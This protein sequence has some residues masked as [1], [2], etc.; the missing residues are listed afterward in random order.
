METVELTWK[1]TLEVCSEVLFRCLL[2]GIVVGLYVRTMAPFAM[3]ENPNAYFT[4]NQIL[5]LPPKLGWLVGC[6]A[7][8]ISVLPV[9]RSVLKRDFSDFRV[10]L[11]P[12][13]RRTE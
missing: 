9:T 1:R 5:D 3:M 2:V 10:I 11:V 13:R 8:L 12:R 4:A 6:L 7:A